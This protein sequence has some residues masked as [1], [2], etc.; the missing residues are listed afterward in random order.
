MFIFDF[1]NI[2]DGYF[3]LYCS[4]IKKKS[5]N[6]VKF[7]KSIVKYGHDDTELSFQLSL[8]E[9]KVNHIENPVE[10]GD[11]DSSLV[12]LKKTKE[13]LENLMLLYKNRQIDSNF[14]KLILL[15]KWLSNLKLTY[16]ISKCYL[17]LEKN[18]FKNLKGNNPN[19]LAFNLFRIGY[20]C[21]L[22]TN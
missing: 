6:K 10:H 20:L 5:F 11:I 3:F 7:D 8:L 2:P 21:T 14:V 1:H 17:L 18:I 9:A 4:L 13:A 12:Y 19:L 16:M 22:K 15:F